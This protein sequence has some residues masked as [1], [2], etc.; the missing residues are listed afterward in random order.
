MDITHSRIR[1]PDETIFKRNIGDGP[2]QH[3]RPW[4]G[5]ICYSYRHLPECLNVFKEGWPNPPSKRNLDQGQNTVINQTSP[6]VSRSS[7][8][9]DLSSNVKLWV[10]VAISAILAVACVGSLVCAFKS[11]QVRR[12]SADGDA[13]MGYDGEKVVAFK[14]GTVELSA[15]TVYEAKLKNTLPEVENGKGTPFADVDV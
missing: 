11:R 15:G 10:F 1:W 7:Y 4:N 14:M 9:Q 12:R 13:L 5:K 3:P 2:G 8:E 6:A